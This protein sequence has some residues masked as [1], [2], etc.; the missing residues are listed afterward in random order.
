MH[1]NEHTDHKN[2]NK[3]TNFG[4]NIHEKKLLI[5]IMVFYNW[6]LSYLSLELLGM[7]EFKWMIIIDG[8]IFM[9]GLEVTLFSMRCHD[10]RLD[11]CVLPEIC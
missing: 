6:A 3:I 1:I 5:I 2:S 10:I 9:P 11:Y 7:P 8:L 4:C